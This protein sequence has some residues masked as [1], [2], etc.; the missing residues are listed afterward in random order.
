MSFLVRPFGG[1]VFGPLGD[2][3]L[4]WGWRIPFLLALPIGLVGLYLRMRLGETPAFEQ[5]V[6]K[7]EQREGTSTKE[8]FRLIFARHWRALLLVGGLMIA[9]TFLGRLSG[10]VGRRPILMTGSIALIVLGIPMVLA[11][12]VGGIAPTFLGLMMGLSPTAE[13]HGVAVRRRVG[14][15]PSREP[16]AAAPG[17]A[18]S[19]DAGLG[20]LYRLRP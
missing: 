16:A 10:R 4:P 15:G 2:R 6:A 1:L 18:R 9:V 13:S 20:C 5:M 12:Q 7:S 14:P 17:R 3:M 11:L 19:G 8:E